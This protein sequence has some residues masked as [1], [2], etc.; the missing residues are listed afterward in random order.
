M[1]H[2]RFISLFLGCHL[3][4]TVKGE[5]ITVSSPTQTEED[6]HG[7]VMPE[8]YK[9]DSCKAVIHHINEEM[10]KK[11]PGNRRLPEWEYTDVFDET[12]EKSFDEYGVEDLNGQTVLSGPG[13]PG[14]KKTSAQGFGSVK[15][16][17][18]KWKRRLQEFCKTMINDVVGAKALY[19][20]YNED[21]RLFDDEV[22]YRD[23]RDCSTAETRRVLAEMDAKK[24]AKE[25]P[26]KKK[27]K[28]D[29]TENVPQTPKVNSGL[30]RAHEAQTGA[31]GSAKPAAITAEAFFQNLA[32]KH[33]LPQDTYTK[34]RTEK[35]WRKVLLE[36]AGKLLQSSHS[37]L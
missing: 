20:M 7:Y 29:K 26:P 24:A 5:S 18:G 11:A 28:K 9:C 2:Y 13:L 35:Q 27:S 14:N 10:Q 6:L 19:D 17:G 12:C 31:S 8:Q 23:T 36:A 32:K 33:K 15:M 21:G 37:E 3:R 22:C 30:N 34:A 4:G 1:A 25:P 16:K